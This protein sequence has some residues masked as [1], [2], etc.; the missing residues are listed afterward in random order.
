LSN[1]RAC[2]HKSERGVNR[3]KKFQ[4]RLVRLENGMRV[5]P[6]ED[7][8]P[9]ISAIKEACADGRIPEA[10]CLLVDYLEPKL[11]KCGD[12]QRALAEFVLQGDPVLSK[13]DINSLEQIR[14]YCDQ[15]QEESA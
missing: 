3:M 10:A 14:D 11:Q 12:D 5:I 2:T 1:R 9:T 6:A 8:S 7:C 13:L 15:I 4:T